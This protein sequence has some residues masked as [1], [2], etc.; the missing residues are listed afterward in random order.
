[1]IDFQCHGEWVGTLDPINITP[2]KLLNLIR[3][4]AI[5][6]GEI[7]VNFR[8]VYQTL[9]CINRAGQVCWKSHDHKTLKRADVYDRLRDMRKG[10][11]I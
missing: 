8:M 11:V 3:E 5:C 4:F 2:N 6:Y 7:E 10:G 1:M 9:Y